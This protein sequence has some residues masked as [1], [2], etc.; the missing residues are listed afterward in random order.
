MKLWPNLLASPFVTE[1]SQPMYLV[2][3]MDVL[4]LQQTLTVDNA[5]LDLFLVYRP[6]VQEHITHGGS[7]CI[8]N[9]YYWF[10]PNGPEDAKLYEYSL[11]P[12]TIEPNSG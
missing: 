10:N 5:R 8:D 11:D 6:E 2:P 12:A 9:K 4:N 3:G 1:L 7:V